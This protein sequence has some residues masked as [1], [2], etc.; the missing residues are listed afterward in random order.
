V[1]QYTSQKESF[2]TR[3]EWFIILAFIIVGNIFI[4]I[5]MRYENAIYYWDLSN[6]WI[7]TLELKNLFTQGLAPSISAIMQSINVADYNY[8]GA[9]ILMPFQYIFGFSRTAHIHGI[10]NMFVIPAAI[11]LAYI[12][13]LLVKK[14][15]HNWKPAYLAIPIIATL[16][17][18]LLLSPS[19][20]G[21]VDA[22]GIIFT[23]AAVFLYFK[24]GLDGRIS[25][26]ISMGIL[27]GLAGL[28]RRWYYFW[29]VTFI[30]MLCIFEVL[31]VLYQYAKQK[32]KNRRTILPPELIRRV[33]NYSITGISIAILIGSVSYTVLKRVL[34]TNYRDI[35]T[36]Y[37]P[38]L[39]IIFSNSIQFFGLLFLFFVILGAGI[40]LFEKKTR[41]EAVFLILPIIIIFFWF[42]SIQSFGHHQFL[43]FALSMILLVTLGITRVL[44]FIKKT[45]IR[46]SIVILLIALFITSIY[47]TYVPASQKIRTPPVNA[48][49]G[50]SNFPR[51]FEHKEEMTKIYYDLVYMTPENE[52]IYVLPS[53][54]QMGDGILRNVG[55]PLINTQR[56]D[57]VLPAY[58]VDRLG[59]PN[60]FFRATYVVISIPEQY[61]LNKDEQS[62]IHLLS[63]SLLKN[64]SIGRHYE[65]LP[66]EYM[67]G[68][69][70]ILVYK[71]MSAVTTEDVVELSRILKNKYP[72]NE[73]VYTIHETGY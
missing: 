71:K 33:R 48:L 66:K 29:I 59:F 39:N 21:Y 6:Y 36:A 57:K 18:P 37:R 68:D 73:N 72:N 35:Y 26:Y 31:P 14:F 17:R 41:K 70:K 58:G 11:T 54:Y 15:Y 32:I 69:I 38:P 12:T 50:T 9:V 60:H 43:L 42:S 2:F 24:Y 1:L 4:T 22:G 63:E 30:V 56:M 16:A 55:L 45:I 64:D 10:F 8:L 20:N 49:S 46:R 40:L 61:H 52:T 62:I 3:N 23:G 28:F 34:L 19:L 47:F 65:K 67:L 44:L 5:F 27:L 25:V 51:I 53:S 7:K 13:K